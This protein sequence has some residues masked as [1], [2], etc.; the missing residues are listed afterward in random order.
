ML[1][2]TI[3]RKI[4]FIDLVHVFLAEEY[5]PELSQ[6]NIVVHVYS[7]NSGNSLQESTT[8]YVNLEKEENEL[9]QNMSKMNRYM[10]RR[11]KKE[12]YEV[13]IKD[14]PTDS[15]LKEFQ[16]FYNEF[17]KVKKICN[18]NNFRLNTLRL[19]RDEKALVFTKL[20]NTQ[21]E[22][23][24]Y[25]IYLT[26]K[27]LVLNYYTCTAVWVQERPDL[28]QE[29]RFA[30]RYLLWENMMLF[31]QRGFKIYDYGKITAVNE[32]NKFKKDFGFKGAI[33]YHGHETQSL[34]GKVIIK[35]NIMRA[36][37]MRKFV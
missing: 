36:Q 29:I 35:L 31:K 21:G 6:K 18:I 4:P 27:N 5:E 1:L 22:A 13:I 2:I 25:R 12:A 16:Q 30:N 26:D 20:Q 17:V 14:N 19:L 34:A 7:R 10:L 15:D 3:K 23:L 11:A 32:I 9:L 8:Y 28:K 33:T 37:L 24:C